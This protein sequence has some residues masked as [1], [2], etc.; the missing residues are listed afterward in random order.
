MAKLC[1]LFWIIYDK[2][3]WLVVTRASL[4]LPIRFYF[5]ENE[6]FFIFTNMIFQVILKLLPILQLLGPYVEF[7]SIFWLQALLKNFLWFKSRDIWYQKS[8]P[9]S[10]LYNGNKIMVIQRI[11]PFLL[12]KTFIV[13]TPPPKCRIWKSL[14]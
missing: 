9:G 11:N 2:F 1:I 10:E 6:K 3:C 4:G 8:P 5:G 13:Y 7:C 14:L 12:K